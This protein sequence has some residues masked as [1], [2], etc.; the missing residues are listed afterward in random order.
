MVALLHVKGVS[1]IPLKDC[2]VLPFQK[3]VFNI[4]IYVGSDGLTNGGKEIDQGGHRGK[5]RKLEETYT[6]G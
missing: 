5:H 1:F 2:E 3:N 6:G 4:Y